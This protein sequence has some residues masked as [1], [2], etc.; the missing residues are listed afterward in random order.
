MPRGGTQAIFDKDHYLAFFH[1]WKDFPTIQSNGKKI[2]HYTIG[3]YTFDAHPPFA[4]TAVSPEPLV[5]KDFYQPPYYKTWKP[6]RC[7]FPCGMVLSE[8]FVW[9]SYGRQDHEIWIAKIDKKSLLQSLVPVNL[10][11]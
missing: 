9:I 1:S 5:S 10:S 4:I 2:A 3:A 8:D 11:H 6:M 7:I